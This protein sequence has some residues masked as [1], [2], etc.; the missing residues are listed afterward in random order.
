MIRGKYLSGRDDL[1]EIYQLREAVFQKEL[2]FPAEL[3]RDGYDGLAIHAIAYD[4]KRPAATG[5]ILFDGEIYRMS[6]VAVK[7]EFRGKGYGEFIVRMLIN[8]AL[9]SGAREIYVSTLAGGRGMFERIG[10][11]VCG[12]EYENGGLIYLPMWLPAEKLNKCCQCQGAQGLNDS[13]DNG[14]AYPAESGPDQVPL[15]DAYTAADTG[16]G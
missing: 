8:K 4:E 3:E 2:G 6:R 14:Q 12:Q 16:R 11:E 5:R 1:S 10:F 15:P 13:P 7:D 9:L